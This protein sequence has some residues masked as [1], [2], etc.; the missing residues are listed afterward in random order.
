MQGSER[1]NNRE[2]SCHICRLDRR[3]EEKSLYMKGIGEDIDLHVQR[4]WIRRRALV[5]LAGDDAGALLVASASSRLL[6]KA[7][8][9]PNLALLLRLHGVVLP[10]LATPRLLLLLAR[11][12]SGLRAAI[13]VV[14]EVQQEQ[15]RRQG[16]RRGRCSTSSSTCASI[17][18]LSYKRLVRSGLEGRGSRARRVTRRDLLHLFFTSC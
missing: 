18:P 9:T 5:L 16:E 12:A 2:V 1:I 3:E 13:A 14:H 4:E 6:V 15:Q 8:S 17:H 7:C 10:L 11:L